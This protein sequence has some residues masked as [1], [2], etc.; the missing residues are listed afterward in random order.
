MLINILFSSQSLYEF[1]FMSWVFG[2][3]AIMHV[4]EFFLVLVR[5]TISVYVIKPN[6]TSYT[7]PGPSLNQLVDRIACC[8]LYFVNNYSR[9]SIN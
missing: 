4:A 8:V 6:L 9:N 7:D 2:Q 1:G 3:I 5:Q